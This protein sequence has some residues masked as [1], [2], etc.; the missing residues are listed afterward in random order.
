MA[1][2]WMGA[3]V[4]ARSHNPP[5]KPHSTSLV[6][7]WNTELLFSDPDMNWMLLT[8]AKVIVLSLC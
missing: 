6:G 5:I 8:K 1:F 4:H 2:Q 7:T 3:R